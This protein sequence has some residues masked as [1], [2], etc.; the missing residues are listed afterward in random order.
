MAPTALTSPGESLGNAGKEHYGHA[1][2]NQENRG[3]SHFASLC[4]ANKIQAPAANCA[5]THGTAPG[6][7]S[8]SRAYLSQRSAADECGSV[9][10]VLGEGLAGCNQLGSG[11][12]NE[13]VL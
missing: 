11:Q 13:R 7:R 8:H 6:C 12:T 2:E 3:T 9:H 10:S 5:T 4:T 1:S